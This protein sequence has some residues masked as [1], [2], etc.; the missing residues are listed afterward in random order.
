[1]LL[2]TYSRFFSRVHQRKQLEPGLELK[3]LQG[4]SPE[5]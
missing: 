5:S 4:T 1:L 2:G 3:I